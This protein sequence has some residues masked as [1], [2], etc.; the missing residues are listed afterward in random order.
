M[1]DDLREA[2]SAGMQRLLD[3]LRRRNKRSC[4]S[5]QNCDTRARLSKDCGMVKNM[6]ARDNALHQT[7]RDAQQRVQDAQEELHSNAQTVEEIE[8][9]MLD[10]HQEFAGFE[11]TN[12]G[13]RASDAGCL[14]QGSAGTVFVEEQLGC[15]ERERTCWAS[16]ENTSTVG[17]SGERQR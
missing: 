11:H 12:E 15:K 2:C 14:E 1:D 4:P 7:I 6:Q 5:M 3:I 16:R 13:R 10:L 17:S 9:D 8:K